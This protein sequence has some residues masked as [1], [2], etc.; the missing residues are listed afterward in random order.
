MTKITNTSTNEFSDKH[1]FVFI[2]DQQEAY[3]ILFAAGVEMDF[4]NE[5]EAWTDIMCDNT[6]PAHR[7][8]F[9]VYGEGSR[10]SNAHAVTLKIEPSASQKETLI[11]FL[12]SFLPE[13]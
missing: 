4:E 2:N 8:W 1:N 3:N 9:A 12:I 10:M 13:Y 6:D 5:Q 11:A 7:E